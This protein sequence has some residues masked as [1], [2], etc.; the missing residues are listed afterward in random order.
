VTILQN[1]IQSISFVKELLY[2]CCEIYVI[3]FN[4]KNIQVL[5]NRLENPHEQ[6]WG[7]ADFHALLESS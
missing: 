2:K 4:G 1:Y 5:K 7:H 3:L 6:K